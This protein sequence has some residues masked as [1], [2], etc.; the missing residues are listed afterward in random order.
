VTRVK[1][2][3]SS[4]V[5]AFLQGEQGADIV[6]TALADEIC[7]AAA[8]WSEIAQ[9]IIASGRDW[10]LARALLQNFGLTVEPVIE[11][12]A[13]W[14]AMRWRRGEGLSLGDRL[15]LATAER[16]Q[17]TV[18]TADKAWGKSSRIKQIR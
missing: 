10:G 18:L 11:A 8:N 12:D 9:Q 16:L 6:E 5:L 2:L 7:C 13:E 4:A 15:C 3:D 1:V 14:A 17:A